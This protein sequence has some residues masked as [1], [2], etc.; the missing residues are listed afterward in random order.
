MT[1]LACCCYCKLYHDYDVVSRLYLRKKVLD[2]RDVSWYNLL[3]HLLSSNDRLRINQMEDVP[4]GIDE[5]AET[6]GVSTRTVQRWAGRGLP[7]HR[8]GK[9]L[10]FYL[11]EVNAWIKGHGNESHNDDSR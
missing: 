1:I 5:L 3:W 7:V 6:L 2:W 10:F 11:S 4:I 9:R 8:P